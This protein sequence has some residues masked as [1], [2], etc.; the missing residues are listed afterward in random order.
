MRG[1]LG[2]ACF[3]N[4]MKMRETRFF[5]AHMM[6]PGV[7]FLLHKFKVNLKRFSVVHVMECRS[8]KAFAASDLLRNQRIA[9]RVY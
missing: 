8:S 6:K 4:L 7:D 3:C 5:F 1:A 9:F 2:H